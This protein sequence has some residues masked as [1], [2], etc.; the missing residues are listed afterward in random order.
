ML[1]D[2]ERLAHELQDVVRGFVAMQNEYEV[3]D[4]GRDGDLSA[5]YFAVVNGLSLSADAV[6]SWIDYLR[7]KINNGEY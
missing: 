1:E 5:S 2:L 7:E 6:D 3:L 4:K